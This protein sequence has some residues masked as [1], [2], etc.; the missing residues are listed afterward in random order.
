MKDWNIIRKNLRD[1]C[2]PMKKLPLDCVRFS[3]GNTTEHELAKAKECLKLHQQGRTFA[4]EVI[5]LNG[6]RP[7]IMVFDLEEPMV[8]E[9]ATTESEESLI[10]KAN[11]YMGL[12][13]EVVRT[14]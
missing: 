11:D 10:K 13:I 8:I 3:K 4:T 1:Y 6:K 12:R 9:I 5:L 14:R 7:D 2:D